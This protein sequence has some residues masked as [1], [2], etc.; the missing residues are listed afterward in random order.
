MDNLNRQRKNEKYD[1]FK[2]WRMEHRKER[3]ILQRANLENSSFVFQDMVEADFAEAILRNS[4][5]YH[6]NFRGA[7][8]KKAD[9]SHSIL[10]YCNFFIATFTEANL[11]NTELDFSI[12][13][14]AILYNA[15]L[16]NSSLI[17]V[18][19][20]GAFLQHCNLK[21]ADLSFANLN[22]PWLVG[23]DFTEA[24]LGGTI[25]GDCDLSKC[26]GLETVI[27]NSPS[28]I[29]LSTLIKTFKGSNNSFSSAAAIF[30]LNA[31]VSKT[32]LEKIPN[33]IAKTQYYSSFICYGEPDRVFAEKLV[34]DLRARGVSC[35]L[36]SMD[37][38]PGERTWSEIFQKMKT[39]E[40]M[41]VICSSRVL[42]RDGVL[43]EIERQIDENPDKIIPISLDNIWKEDGFRVI[44]GKYN[45]KPFLLDRNYV[46]FS[47]DAR[48][49]DSLETLLRGLRKKNNES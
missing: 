36:Y 14:G 47:D 15:N 41:I 40:K 12:L 7:N 23:T 48:Y 3:L 22:D 27:H 31:G 8:F 16:I 26:I 42:I 17:Q 19:L 32:L 1:A 24:T 37:F 28:I 45:L 38:T 34:E 18:N 20:S 43:K 9:L 29:D 2:F 11:M 33:I 46:D 25:I 44:R 39:T 13:V 35:W 21:N 6:S 49:E 10:S 4:F 30:F 5:C